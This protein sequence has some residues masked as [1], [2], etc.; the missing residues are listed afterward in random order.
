MSQLL[1]I[2]WCLLTY[3][4]LL[5]VSEPLLLAVIYI[6]VI[7]SLRPIHSYLC[8]INNI[9]GNFLRG[10][11]NLCLL[12]VPHPCYIRS[13]FLE[14]FSIGLVQLPSCSLKVLI[15]HC[16]WALQLYFSPAIR[17]GY[18]R[19]VMQIFAVDTLPHWQAATSWFLIQP[20]LLYPEW[21]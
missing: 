9:N 18:C 7:A 3:L 12:A 16:I 10:A 19:T 4:S 6:Y 15:I 8:L 17:N 20:C 11:N 13:L 2:P 1:C 14:N 21:V 5:E